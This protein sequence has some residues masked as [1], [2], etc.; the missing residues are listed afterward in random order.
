[1]ST[2][3]EEIRPKIEPTIKELVDPIGKAE[4]E[5]INKLKVI[6]YLS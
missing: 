3:V 1:M 6:L 4:G 2:A 5:L